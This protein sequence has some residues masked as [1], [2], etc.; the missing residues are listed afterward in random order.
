MVVYNML[1]SKSEIDLAFFLT[2]I[3]FSLVAIGKEFCT[4]FAEFLTAW[5][6]ETLVMKTF[7]S[8]KN[9]FE[10]FGCCIR[11]WFHYLNNLLRGRR[12][13][14]ISKQH[15]SLEQTDIDQIWQSQTKESIVSLSQVEMQYEVLSL[16]L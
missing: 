9:H 1:N 16:M 5:M 15:E 14:K 8:I 6:T 12:A 3:L 11:E 4:I 10:K 13:A 2:L 7:C